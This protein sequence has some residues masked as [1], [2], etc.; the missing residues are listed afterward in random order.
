MLNV[1]L[2]TAALGYLKSGYSLIPVGKDKR[3]L[4]AWKEFQERRASEDEVAQWFDKYPEMQ[5][6]I[7]T[8][9]ISNLTVIDIEAGGDASFIK[10]ETFSVK[11]GGGGIHLYFAFD[12]DFQNMVRVRPLVDVRSEGGYVVAAPSETLKGS[13]SV[14]RGGGCTQMTLETK[15]SL[16][17]AN[18]PRSVHSTGGSG[19]DR[20]IPWSGEIPDLGYEGFGEGERN[21]QMT[22]YIGKVLAN[23]GQPLWTSVGWSMVKGANERNQ[24]PLPEHELRATFRSIMGREQR[25]HPSGRDFGPKTWGPDKEQPQ[26]SVA[27]ETPVETE[28]GPV[29]IKHVSEVAALQSIDTDKAYPLDMLPFDEALLGGLSP[30]DLIVVAGRSGNGKT[31]LIQDW[32][33]TLSGGGITKKDPLPSLWFSY[34]VLSKPLWL[35]FQAMGVDTSIDILM[36]TR[37]E[38]GDLSWI[39]EMIEKG[40]KE[41]GVRV[42]AIDHLGFIGSP[43]GNY[44][45][46]ADAITHTVRHLKKLA[47]K[48]GLIIL[49]P[50]HIR[51]TASKNIDLDDVKDS[52]GI[53]QEADAVFFIERHKEGDTYKDY[54]SIKL[55]KNRKT[56]VPAWGMFT[57]HMGRYQYSPELTEGKQKDN[58]TAKAAREEYRKF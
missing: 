20:G 23:V 46:H 24:P 11:T 4:I 34:E 26:E 42:V 51:K 44:A 5:L 18:N 22:R 52:I 36:P 1:A 25:A 35:K 12:S 55:E 47:V 29:E 48:H 27:R 38:S 33:V 9:R 16:L 31:S 17:G 39:T 43:K 15:T 37:N 10:E 19:A 3:P 21:D 49:L 58:E 54:S 7:V 28:E 6:G 13:Y 8:G 57:F 45:N 14:V 40:V 41:K 2:L 32:T 50:V 53:V 30:G 56:G